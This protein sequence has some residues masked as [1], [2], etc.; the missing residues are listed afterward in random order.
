MRPMFTK[1]T[2]IRFAA[3]AAAMVTTA[4]SLPASAGGVAE[5]N[6][7]YGALVRQD[8]E[9]SVKHFTEAIDSKQLRQ[10]NVA[11]AYQFRGAS[12]LK[13]GRDDEA[14]A[15][16]DQALAINPNLATAYNDRAIA[17]RRKG[18][19][20]HAVADY[21]A[22][23]KLMPN[24]HSFYFNRG[25]AYAKAGRLSDAMADYKNALAYK[26]DSVQ[27]MVAIGDAE[28]LQGHKEGAIAAYGQAMRVSDDVLDVYPGVGE[29]LTAL[30]APPPAASNPAARHVKPTTKVNAAGPAIVPSSNMMV[31]SDSL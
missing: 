23:I 1:Q 22:A 12:L 26:P 31:L 3:C 28:M 8:Y 2:T 24:V 21:D 20:G 19:I 14:I 15:D 25:L 16:F 11:L 4:L 5:F 27:A 29:K 17:F 18:D 13:V 9:G 30:G 10:R 6:A 7:G